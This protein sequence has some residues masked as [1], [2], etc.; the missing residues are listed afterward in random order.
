MKPKQIQA[1]FLNVLLNLKNYHSNPFFSV[2][3]SADNPKWNYNP[4]GFI[5]QIVF[6]EKATAERLPAIRSDGRESFLLSVLK[7]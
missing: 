6:T 4:F 3:S 7:S 5:I 1:N 2:C